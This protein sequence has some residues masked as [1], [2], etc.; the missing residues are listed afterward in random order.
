MR[1]LNAKP[2]VAAVLSLAA[3]CAFAQPVYK[4]VDEDG[5][6]HYSRTLPP[7][8]VDDA[9][10]RL[11]SEGLVTE[12]IDRALTPEERDLLERQ[13]RERAAAEKAAADQA[14]K[15]QLFLSAYPTEDALIRS[16]E[17]SQEILRNERASVESM[18]ADARRNFSRMLREAAALERRGQEVPEGLRSRIAQQRDRLDE[19]N[20]RIAEIDAR[21]AQLED[22]LSADLD[23]HR[24]L[25]ESG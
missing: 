25:T 14:R 16:H 3:T 10:E 18:L 24:R 15:D 5:K 17:S 22:N 9:H 2:L 1:H 20:R 6:V 19:L 7:E 13:E 12:R 8:R 23:R 4:W 11:S 21:S